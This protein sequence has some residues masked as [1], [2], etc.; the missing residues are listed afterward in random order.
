M[1]R[2][3][4]AAVI[5]CV[6]LAASCSKSE[7]I[8]KQN[9]NSVNKNSPVETS[10]NNEEENKKEEN[11]EPEL[12]EADYKGY[13][14]RILNI[15]QDDMWWAIVAA[16]IEEQS[17]EV[18]E[19]A[20]YMR[21]RNIEAK[22]NFLIKEIRMTRSALASAVKKSV[23]AGGDDYDVVFPYTADIPGL[24]Q[25]NLLMDLNKVPHLDFSKPWWTNDVSQYF[26]IGNKLL[27]AMSDILLTDNDD[28]VI[29]MYNKKIAENI[30]VDGADVLYNLVENGKWTFD[31]FAELTKAAS[32]D[33]NGNGIV[34]AKEDRFGLV[35]V[36][37]LYYALIGGFDEYLISKDE[38]DLPYLSC[39]SEKFLKAYQT[40][41]DFMS[42]RE[43]VVREGEDPI[44]GTG[45]TEEVFINDRALM[46]VQVLSCCRLYREMGSDFGILP[47]PKL[48]ENQKKYCSYMCGSTCIALPATNTD[49]DRTGLILEALS[50]ES[51][52]LVI[53]AYYDV[54]LS[55][56]YLRDEGSYKMLD[57][58]LEN[59]VYDIC[60]TIYDWS[61]FTGQVAALAK[62]GDLNFSTV[63]EKNE[64]KVEAAIQKTI[65]AYIL[66]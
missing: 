13:E 61:G 12:P 14:F 23:G 34:D 50:A 7:D 51:R 5:I 39:K 32:A 24:V 41:T 26:S 6:I 55:A 30:G 44:E 16:D 48:D 66:A 10:I 4:L 57:I 38:N 59:R 11:F 47:L 36:N 8:S 2:I 28:V 3:I 20:I 60:T 43:W 49:P 1:K 53:P 15:T 54:A 31:K 25:N 62:K 27:F 22:Y 46:C 45:R 65:E 56:K 40:A 37:W 63:I 52:K 19:D 42:R 64:S 9:N 33:T 58:I 17:G 21:N 29:T 18:V 35:C